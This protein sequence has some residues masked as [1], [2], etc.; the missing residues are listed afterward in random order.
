MQ[1]STLTCMAATLDMDLART[2]SGSESKVEKG[3][4]EME[5][6]GI[7]TEVFIK[8]I[9]LIIYHKC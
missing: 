2:E 4:S 6:L 5:D 8:T 3:A 1:E 9:N 7:Q